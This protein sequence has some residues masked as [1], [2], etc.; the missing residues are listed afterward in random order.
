MRTTDV[1]FNENSGNNCARLSRID[2]NNG[3][4]QQEENLLPNGRTGRAI[5]KQSS[6]SKGV[7]SKKQDAG[8]R[9][10]PYERAER[11]M[12]ISET[13]HCPNNVRIICFHC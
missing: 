7:G 12:A 8:K 1:L 4:V 13:K 9:A 10:E 11:R 2:S 6:G 3:E 5:Q